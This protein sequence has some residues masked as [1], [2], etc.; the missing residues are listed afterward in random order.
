MPEL[1]RPVAEYIKA[2]VKRLSTLPVPICRDLGGRFC[3]HWEY[4]ICLMGLLP[5]ATN[6]MPNGMSDFFFG[7]FSVPFGEENAEAIAKEYQEVR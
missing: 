5:E 3:L 2:K 1:A 7:G 4:D 6:K